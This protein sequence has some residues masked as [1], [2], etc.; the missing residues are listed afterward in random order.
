M[1]HSQPRLVRLLS[2]WALALVLAAPLPLD[3][4]QRTGPFTQ[5]S[6]SLRSRTVDQQHVRLELAFDFEKQ[7]IRGQAVHDLVLFQAASQIELD[8]AEMKVERVSE[9]SERAN[10]PRELKYSQRDQTVAIDLGSERPA[11][12]SL[13][14]AIDYSIDKPRHGAHFVEPDA[15]EP[16]QPRMVWTQSEP[17]YARYWFP[18]FD[19]PSDRLTSEIRATVPSEY[20]TLSNGTLESKVANSDGTT[21][22]HWK[23][24]KSHVPYL[25]SI[26]AGDFE[27]LEHQADGIPIQS[28][29]PRGRLADAPR[30]FDKTPAMLQYFN[31]QIGIA[32][33][34]PK[35]A[36]ICVDEYGWGG[37]EHTSATTLNLGTLHDER[38]HLDVSS[39]NL[40][41]HEL[42]HQ[43]W[44]DLLTCKDWGE[45]WLN[46]SFATYFATLWTEEDLGWD[47][48]A[49][50][51]AGDADSY[52]AEDARYRRSIVNYRYNTPEPCV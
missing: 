27:V 6:R 50:E 9:Q 40:V 42:V 8:A 37:M 45:I 23:Q 44:G 49:W 16:S 1:T 48:A 28:Y 38:A 15:D 47:E 19:H 4:Q 20:V 43:W 36:Q 34:W 51:R 24:A 32:Y 41:A 29:V 18:C 12:A 22:W 39:D 10:S 25:M 17:E 13:R 52:M 11:G 26:V 3:A 21:T 5:P 31:R 46:E 33:P 30:S 35:Y 7:S 14:L 2:L